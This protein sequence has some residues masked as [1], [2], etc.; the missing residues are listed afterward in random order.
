MTGAEGTRVVALIPCHRTPPAES[1]VRHVVAQADEVL[2]VD[3]GMPG[4]EAAELE[5]LAARVGAE[6]VHTQHGGKGH[7]IVA[8]LSR[9][10]MAGRGLAVVI[11]DADGQH[12][13]EAIPRFLAASAHADLVVGDRFS[14]PAQVPR[15]AGSRTPSRARSSRGRPGRL[16]PTASA[17]CGSSRGVR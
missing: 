4:P 12:P 11:L 7:A 6:V 8:G 9:L 14:R 15:L 2:V 5:R 3:D 10:E 13:P 1:L 16:S 17:A